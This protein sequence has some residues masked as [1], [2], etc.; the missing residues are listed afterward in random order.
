MR[1]GACATGLSVTPGRGSP[2][3][4]AEAGGEKKK[5]NRGGS[6]SRQSTASPVGT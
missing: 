4:R 2:F 1:A 5:L 6:A 3:R